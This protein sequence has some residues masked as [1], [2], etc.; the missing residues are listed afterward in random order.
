M[1]PDNL[2]RP[3]LAFDKNGKVGLPMGQ[4]A[5]RRQGRIQGGKLMHHRRR[6][7]LARDGGGT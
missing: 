3:N 5:A 2:P 4:K 7:A 6:Q 1:R